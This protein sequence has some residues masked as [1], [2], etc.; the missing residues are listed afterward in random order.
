M[1]IT[2]NNNN[3]P[4]LDNE[5]QDNDSDLKNNTI[6]FKSSVSTKKIITE[7]YCQPD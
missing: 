5:S 6:I 7:V 3:E 4:R 1:D 2:I